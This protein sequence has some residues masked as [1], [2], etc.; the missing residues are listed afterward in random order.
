MPTGLG[1][2]EK[3]IQMIIESLR[4]KKNATPAKPVSPASPASPVAPTTAPPVAG[5]G[6][7]TKSEPKPAPAEKPSGDSMYKNLSKELKNTLKKMGINI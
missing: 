6:I 2:L 3:P 1:G 4:G 5:V 7:P